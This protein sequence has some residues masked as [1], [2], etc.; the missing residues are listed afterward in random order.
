MRGFLSIRRVSGAKWIGEARSN[1][2][3]DLHLLLKLRAPRLGLNKLSMFLDVNTFKTIVEHAPLISIDL[4]V[5]NGAGRVLLGRRLNR[6]AQGF[7]FVPGGR[8]HK[9]EPLDAAF[10]RLAEAELGLPL[11]RDQASFLGVYQHFYPDNFSGTD[12]STH[13][14]VLA[15]KLWISELAHLP[16][17]QHSNYCWFSPVDLLADEQVHEN[18]KAYFK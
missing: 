4:V 12:F 1:R 2:E 17:E 11:R 10:V 8:V 5:H 14:V 3:N 18:S 13:Y 15:Y 7:W 6:P 9:D 16:T